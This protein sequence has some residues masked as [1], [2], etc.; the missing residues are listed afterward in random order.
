MKSLNTVILLLVCGIGPATAQTLPAAPN[1]LFI[2]IDDQAWDATSVQ[3]IPGE[4]FSHTANYRMPNLEQLASEGIIF[5]QA[6]ATHPKCEGSRSGIT[7]SKLPIPK[8]PC[9]KATTSLSTIGT[10]EKGFFTTCPPI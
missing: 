3:M 5:S 6:Y 8:R 4:S 7:M 1:F 9:A 2:F 10:R